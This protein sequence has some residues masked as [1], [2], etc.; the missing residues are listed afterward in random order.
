[1]KKSQ[2]YIEEAEVNNCIIMYVRHTLILSHGRAQ[3]ELINGDFR[4]IA[5]YISKKIQHSVMWNTNRKSYVVYQMV[6]M[7]HSYKAGSSSPIML[8]TFF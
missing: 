4:P 5:C 8:H 3:R 7:S 6:H 2:Y 1:M